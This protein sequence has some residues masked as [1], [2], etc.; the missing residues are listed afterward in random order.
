MAYLQY[1]KQ[2]EYAQLLVYPQ[3]LHFLELLVSCHRLIANDSADLWGA[4]Q[5]EAF[6][7]ELANPQFIDSVLYRQ[8]FN[9]WR[10]DQANRMRQAM[11]LLEEQARAA[12]QATDTA[13]PAAVDE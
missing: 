7:K 10:F 5:T 13:V 4:Q 3:C 6:R 1:W 12:K 8:Q 2:A 9:H 11:R